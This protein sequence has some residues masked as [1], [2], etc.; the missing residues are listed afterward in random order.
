VLGV[1]AMDGELAQAGNQDAADALEPVPPVTAMQL[2]LQAS[3]RIHFLI[4]GAMSSQRYAESKRRSCYVPTGRDIAPWVLRVR[5]S[6]VLQ[7]QQQGQHNGPKG[8]EALRRRGPESGGEVEDRLGLF[9]RG[10][11]IFG[12]LIRRSQVRILAGALPRSPRGMMGRQRPKEL[13]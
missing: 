5:A 2:H 13:R 4:G 7:G 8:P 12:L 3:R 9:R 10:W 11:P 1:V 6:M